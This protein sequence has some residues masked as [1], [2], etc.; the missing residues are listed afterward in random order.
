M[1]YLLSPLLL[2]FLAA[3]NNTPQPVVGTLERERL[4]LAAPQTE[5]VADWLIAEGDHVA[6]NTPLLQLD[7]SRQ[8]ATVMRLTALHDQAKNHLDE[9]LNGPRHE[10]IRAARAELAGAEARL[11]DAA[12]QLTRTRELVASGVRSAAELDTAQSTHDAAQAA[13]TAAKA[14]L[15]ALLAGTRDEALAQAN[16]ALAAAQA[17]LD[18][19]KIDLQRLTIRAPAAGF[20]EALPYH[21]GEQAAAGATVVVLLADT[22][23]YASVYV[24]QALHAHLQPGMPATVHV[25]GLEK[26]LAGRVRYIA[27][28]AAFTPY[29]ALTEHDRD[30]LSYLVKVDIDV[31][32]NT[33]LP[34]GAPLS[35]TFQ[36]PDA[37][38]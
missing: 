38:P 17:A 4:A 23:V 5:I 30:H 28:D 18:A 32:P 11:Q 3:C 20:V 2:I 19:A 22:P 16:A 36:S 37:R 35:V 10:D 33:W 26:P 8:Q 21:P 29:Y 15:D 6:A 24:P 13:R 34:V 14:R 25:A 9:L 7:K 12:A 31:P 1:K 27:G